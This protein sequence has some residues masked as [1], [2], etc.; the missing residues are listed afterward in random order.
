MFGRSI[1]LFQQFANIHF[2]DFGSNL[3]KNKIS[4]F[5]SFKS[6][7][8]VGDGEGS[9]EGVCYKILRGGYAKHFS[10]A[11]MYITKIREQ[12]DTIQVNGTD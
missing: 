7:I 8:V 12:T 6:A 5:L 9:K 2:Q 11:T 3:E 1:S 4:V 10:Y